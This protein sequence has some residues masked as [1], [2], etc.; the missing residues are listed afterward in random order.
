[1]CGVFFTHKKRNI[2]HGQN[3]GG[4]LTLEKASYS[5]RLKNVARQVGIHLCGASGENA[6]RD[7]FHILVRGK[8]DTRRRLGRRT[9]QQSSATIFTLGS[10]FHVFN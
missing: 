7:Q 1:V 9:G 6:D 4:G 8:V 3:F 10:A 2:Q 5:L